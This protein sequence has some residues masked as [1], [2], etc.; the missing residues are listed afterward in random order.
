MVRGRSQG[1]ATWMLERKGVGRADANHS[2]PA[3]TSTGKQS[4]EYVFW[5]QI[6]AITQQGRAQVPGVLQPQ[7]ST[8]HTRTGS[9]PS[10]TTPMPGC[11]PPSKLFTFLSCSSIQGNVKL[12]A[13]HSP[14]EDP[15]DFHVYQWDFLSIKR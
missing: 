5:V 11:Y 1:Q 4:E 8:N 10:T 14:W 15:E 13:L 6:A 12:T 3:G 2:G 9:A 7:L